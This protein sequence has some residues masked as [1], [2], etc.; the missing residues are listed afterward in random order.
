MEKVMS[1]TIPSFAEQRMV[2]KQRIEELEAENARLR[3]ALERI[4]LGHM[5]GWTMAELAKST[6]E[7][8]DE[9]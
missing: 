6:L 1:E 2:F 7:S 9:I 5:T 3:Q 4:A 8:I